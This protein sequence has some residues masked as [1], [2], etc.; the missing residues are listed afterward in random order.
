MKRTQLVR[1][2]LA[3]V[4]LVSTAPLLAFSLQGLAGNVSPIVEPLA[5]SSAR[6]MAVDLITI[7]DYDNGWF[8]Q[9]TLSAT[10]NANGRCEVIT[11]GGYNIVSGTIEPY[12]RLIFSLNAY[13]KYSHADWQGNNT[14]QWIT[15]AY[16]D[17]IYAD[18]RLQMI[19][20]KEITP[21][22]DIPY[23]L[24][25]Y[26]YDQQSGKLASIEE[27]YYMLDQQNPPKNKFEYTWDTNGRQSGVQ[28]YGLYD[29]D[30]G[31][32]QGNFTQILYRVDDTSS[33]ADH[34]SYL[35]HYYPFVPEFA[36]G[37]NPFR[38]ADKVLYSLM[39]NGDAAAG[40]TNHY[41]YDTSG[42]LDQIHTYL[43]TMDG[44]LYRDND[45]AWN[46]GLISSS[47]IR[48]MDWPSSEMLPSSRNLYSYTQVVANEDP[49][50]PLQIA[51]LNV[52]P[53]PFNP[54]ANIEY[55]LNKA[56][57][58]KLEVFNQK[59]QRVNVLVDGPQASGRHDIRWNGTDA[60]GRL[61]PSGIYFLRVSSGKDCRTTKAVLAK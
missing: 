45:F 46:G 10:Y 9:E 6:G 19:L 49:V 28:E 60:T 54:S 32:V 21:E 33:Y 29:Y 37:V 16:S 43:G 17:W 22:G 23:F 57:N 58:V 4:L 15:S 44:I 40:T 38:I 12:Y 55:H 34:L 41:I 30:D 25:R 48:Q 14:G 26:T 24:V 27:I 31:W 50:V 2:S 47:T 59:G 5:V 35:E 20:T 53:N 3:I 39:P 42:R 7:Q 13:G 56:D 8:S 61:V 51:S 1:L 11:A 52:S 18:N 36:F